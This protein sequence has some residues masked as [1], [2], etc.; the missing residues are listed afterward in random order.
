M[1]NQKH[2]L[3]M[4]KILE[5]SVRDGKNRNREKVETSVVNRNIKNRCLR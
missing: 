5:T 1:K 2:L 4:I 3:E